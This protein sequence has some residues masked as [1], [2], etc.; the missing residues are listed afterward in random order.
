VA[1]APGSVLVSAQSSP[2]LIAE[3]WFTA[4]GSLGGVCAEETS[5]QGSCGVQSTRLTG[6]AAQRIFLVVRLTSSASKEE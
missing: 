4:H 2:P 5:S 6:L 1:L 3:T